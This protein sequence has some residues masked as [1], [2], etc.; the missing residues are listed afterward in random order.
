MGS[1]AEDRLRED[2]LRE[3]QQIMVRQSDAGVFD[4]IRQFW[5]GLHGHDTFLQFEQSRMFLQCV[6]CGHQSPGW[7]L[8]QAP[9]SVTV[10]APRRTQPVAVRPRLIGARRVA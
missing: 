2:R 10:R 9:P 4:R 7:E 8:D 6:S 5:C 3:D 1:F